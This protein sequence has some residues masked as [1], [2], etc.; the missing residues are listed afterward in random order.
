[1]IL[2]KLSGYGI[3]F[4][5]LIAS[6]GISSCTQDTR[7]KNPDGETLAKVTI[8]QTGEFLLY[9]ALYIA[10]DGGFFEQEGLDVNIISAGGDE[11]AVAAVI[12]GQA[13]FAVGDPTFAAIANERGIDVEVIASVVNG[14]PF[15]GVT[16]KDETVEAFAN[17]GLNGLSVATFPSPSTAYTLQRDMFE[18]AGLKPNI[19]EGAFGSI[20]NVVRAGQ[21]DIA[22]ELEPNVAL[23]ETEGATVLYSL[24]KIYGDFAITGMT[25]DAAYAKKNP[26]TVNSTL[27]A[28]QSAMNFARTD[29]EAAL[30]LLDDRFPE[31]DNSVIQAGLLRMIDENIIPESILMQPSSWNKAVALRVEVGDIQNEQ[32]AQGVLNSQWAKRLLNAE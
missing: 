26:E 27:S 2:S 13:D 22:L 8:A 29:T 1:M 15:W 14:V 21:A 18:D 6:I 28:L 12:S 3:T 16:F 4:G 7:G 10:E 11:K 5:F 25:V 9:S 32:A 24:S 17:S 31:L 23:A 19:V 20:L 30:D